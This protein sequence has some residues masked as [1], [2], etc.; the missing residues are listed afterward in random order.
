MEPDSSINRDETF[1]RNAMTSFIQIAALT[2]LVVYSLMIVG[3]FAKIVIWGGI[4]AVAVYPVFKKLAQVL[5][6][7]RKLASIVL[8]LIALIILLVPGWFL[9]ASTIDTAKTLVTDIRAG[10]LVVP[11]PNDSVAGWPLVGE[12][13][14]AAWSALA[15][16]IGDFVQQ[17]RAEVRQ[18]AEWLLGAATSLAG[19]LL[20]FAVSAIIAGVLMM[21]SG[22]GHEFCRRILDPIFKGRGEHFTDLSVATIRSVTNGV[23]GVAVIQ[24]LMASIGFFAIGM[25]APGL[26]TL[27]ILIVAIIQVPT[28]LVMAPVIIWAFSFAEPVPATIFA[29]YAMAV[30]LSDNVLKPMLLGRGVDLPMLVVLIGAIGGMLKFG[31]IGLFIGAV[32]LGVSYQILADWIWNDVNDAEANEEPA[33]AG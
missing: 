26:L 6:G 33:S 22:P 2:I 23:L 20:Q 3:P 30:G 9:A 1:Q 13:V 5:G 31:I 29:V 24:A 11:P 19:G 15:E 7:R 28:I 17:Y 32:I 12:K 25:P 4:L 21:Y 18:V 10:T 16:N 27:L 14:Y 8:V